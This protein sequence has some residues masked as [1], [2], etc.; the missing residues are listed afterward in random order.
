MLKRHHGLLLKEDIAF[1]KEYPN[2]VRLS[3]WVNEL[4]PCNFDVQEQRE[5]RMYENVQ[6]LTS[7]ADFI[8]A[9]RS[10]NIEEAKALLAQNV[11]Y[12]LS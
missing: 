10:S 12:W 2:I 1:S 11:R 5:K 6:M 9:V 4:I 3:N 8:K 7:S